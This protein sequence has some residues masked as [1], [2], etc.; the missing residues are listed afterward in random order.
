MYI[1]FK[2]QLGFKLEESAPNQQLSILYLDQ[3]LI[4]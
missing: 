3:M 4:P 1:I 2:C